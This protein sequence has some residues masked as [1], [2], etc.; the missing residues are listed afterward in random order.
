MDPFTIIGLASSIIP[1]AAKFLGFGKDKQDKV[2]DVADTISTVAKSITG[3]S[4]EKK[5]LEAIKANPEMTLALQQSWQ[6]YEASI[7]HEL[8]ERH[9]A[10]MSSNSWLAKNVRPLCLLGLTSSVIAGALG[11]N[12]LGVDHTSYQSLTEMCTWVY[13]YYF[14]G[15]SVEKNTPFKNGPLPKLPFM[16]K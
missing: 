6:E 14:V 12:Y 1:S 5:A 15:R 13:G 2:K 16:K 3:E 9:K 11:G 8:T 7:Q 4:D 10:D